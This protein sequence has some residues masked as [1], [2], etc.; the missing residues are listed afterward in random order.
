MNFAADVR[1][2]RPSAA[3]PNAKSLHR[4]PKTAFPRRLPRRESSTSSLGPRC[5]TCPSRSRPWFVRILRFQNTKFKLKL[6]WIPLPSSRFH[7]QVFFKFSYSYYDVNLELFHVVKCF[8]KKQKQESN[9]SNFVLARDA[10][11]CPHHGR[12]F[13]RRFFGR[14]SINQ[15]LK[16]H[17]QRV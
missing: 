17:Q 1:K 11:H 14:R 3:V 5:F 12:Q 10:P 15:S 8:L 16:K 9:R 2:S 6:S 4:Q 7:T 13:W